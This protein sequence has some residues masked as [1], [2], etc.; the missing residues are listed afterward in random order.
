M[1]KISS[2][3]VCSALLAGHIIYAQNVGIG[4]ANPLSKLHVAGGL[5]LDTLMGINGAGIMTY[6]INGVVHGLKFNGNI[7]DVLRG[8]GSFGAV[9]GGGGSSSGAFWSLT[10]NSGT[11]PANH[12]VGTTDNQP[13]SFRLNNQWAGRWDGAANNYSIGIG[14]LQKNTSGYSNVAI[15]SKALYN[16][17]AFSNLVA[18][19]DSALFNNGIGAFFGDGIRNTAIG[20]KALYS[21][22]RGNGNTANGFNA[23]YSN[24]TG[25]QNTANGYNALYSNTTSN[26]NTASGV[27]ALNFNTTGGGNTANGN[28]ALFSN[29]TGTYNTAIGY[30]ADVSFGTLSNA[31]AIGAFSKVNSNNK[32]R[33]GN[34]SV[35]VI[36]GQVAYT[37]PSDGRFK[38]HVSENIK[39]LEFIMML[40]PISYNF[41]TRKYDA[42]IKGEDADVQYASM[43]DYTESENLRH[44]GFIA[45]EVENAAIKAGYGFDGV[46]APKNS[47]EAY[48]LSY[49]QFVVPLVKAV[50]EQQVIIEKQ[51]K[52]IVDLLKRVEALEKR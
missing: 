15:G 4:T 40:R 36:E 17:T 47:K 11:E 41:Q 2:L 52:Q 50:Q 18:M 29:T 30:D 1:K 5:R 20:S 19:G 51:Q 32:V 43:T 22:T 44:N 8:D 10:G 7:A 27:F 6:N 12:F 38:T 34:T 28:R 37:F 33:I 46:V 3:L 45:Q 31:T 35:T 9:P 13:L 25:R 26:Y 24:T 39:G 23:L 14:A 21:N 16:N 49:S 42:F 48:G